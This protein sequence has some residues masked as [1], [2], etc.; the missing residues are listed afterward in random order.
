V[1]FQG[2]DFLAQ[3]ATA[4]LDRGRPLTPPCSLRA[5][6]LVQEQDVILQS[7]QHLK[8]NYYLSPHIDTVRGASN[9]DRLSLTKSEQ[10]VFRD[11]E[12]E[13]ISL[14]DTD[15]S[16]S[17][18]RN[19]HNLEVVWTPEWPI[20]SKHYNNSVVTIDVSKGKTEHHNSVDSLLLDALQTEFKVPSSGTESW[21]VVEP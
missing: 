9:H 19:S 17:V 10:D 5:S 18:R 12:E 1:T 7:H 8:A 13:V 16:E 4:S 20:N 21:V 3:E 2:Q 15:M 6:A 11:E 14:D